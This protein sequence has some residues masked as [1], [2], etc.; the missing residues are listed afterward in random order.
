MLART[1][2]HASC[3]GGCHGAGGLAVRPVER[4]LE[5][6]HVAVQRPEPGEEQMPVQVGDLVYAATVR[7]DTER[8]GVARTPARRQAGQASVTV[9]SAA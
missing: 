4:T 6:P 3:F 5:D 1:A 2:S 8:K 7:I 9:D